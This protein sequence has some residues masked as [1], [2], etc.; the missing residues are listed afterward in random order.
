[1]FQPLQGVFVSWKRFL[2]VTASRLTAGGEERGTKGPVRVLKN[3]NMPGCNSDV[4][5]AFFNAKIYPKKTK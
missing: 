1:M 4:F 2:S 5:L 3:E